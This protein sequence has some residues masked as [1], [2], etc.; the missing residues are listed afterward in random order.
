MTAS[1]SHSTTAIEQIDSKGKN[2]SVL[3]K[4]NTITQKTER[5]GRRGTYLNDTLIL[6]L[7]RA[8]KSHVG[9][10]SGLCDNEHFHDLR[11]LSTGENSRVHQLP[12][13]VNEKDT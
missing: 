6:S 11:Y 3:V 4:S 2:I 9:N 8:L 12:I 7:T 13:L 10:L 5:E 1:I